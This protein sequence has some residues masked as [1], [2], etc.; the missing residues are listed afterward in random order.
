MFLTLCTNLL[1]VSRADAR[2][3][4]AEP[5]LSRGGSCGRPQ[6]VLCRTLGVGLGD[7]P[8]ESPAHDPHTR[9]TAVTSTTEMRRA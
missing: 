4:G 2:G 5:V 8:P 7:V 6:D 3:D 1:S 9:P